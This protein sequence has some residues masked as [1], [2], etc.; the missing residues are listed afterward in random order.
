MEMS[1][2]NVGKR[3]SWYLEREVCRGGLSAQSHVLKF[4]DD[5]SVYYRPGYF[6]MPFTSRPL[7]RKRGI[8]FVLRLTTLTVVFL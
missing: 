7:I 1:S 5:I 4:N 6:S 3:I 2:V 8:A